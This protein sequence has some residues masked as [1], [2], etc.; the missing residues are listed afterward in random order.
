MSRYIKKFLKGTFRIDFKR[1][2]SFVIQKKLIPVAIK[3]IKNYPRV[4]LTKSIYRRQDNK[5]PLMKNIG[6]GVF[7][8][9]IGKF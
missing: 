9:N 6:G 3:F 7:L 5:N 1:I 2:K 8:G 4:R